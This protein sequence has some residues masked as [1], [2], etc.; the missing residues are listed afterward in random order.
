M[1]RVTTAA[2][3]ALNLHKDMPVWALVKA[4]STRGH[5]FSTGP[6]PASA[7]QRVHY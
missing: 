6:G 7:G 4:V 3:A 5:T 1:A 2:I